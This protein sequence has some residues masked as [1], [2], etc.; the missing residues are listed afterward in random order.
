MNRYNLLF[1]YGK[2]ILFNRHFCM[3]IIITK[4]Y[5]RNK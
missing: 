1:R 2:R 4:G 5:Y 3:T